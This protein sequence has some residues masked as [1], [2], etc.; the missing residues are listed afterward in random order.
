MGRT[1]QASAPKQRCLIVTTIQE[2]GSGQ[3]CATLNVLR[4]NY[5]SLDCGKVWVPPVKPAPL[6]CGF[7][8]Q[9]PSPLEQQVHSTSQMQMDEAAQQQQPAPAASQQA[10]CAGLLN[11][12]PKALQLT[13]AGTFA[14]L[15]KALHFYHTRCYRQWAGQS[16]RC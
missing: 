13:R 12:L 4:R 14:G 5:G 2:G 7:T 1:S 6:I 11:S 16:C 8:V 3:I 9:I 10:S 15:Q